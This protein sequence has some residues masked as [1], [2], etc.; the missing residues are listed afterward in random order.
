[1]KAIRAAEKELG[2]PASVQTRFQGAAL[3][4][5]ASLTNTSS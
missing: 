2:M 4:F 1:V 5:Q 3:A